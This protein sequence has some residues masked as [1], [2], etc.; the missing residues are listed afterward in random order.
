S[1]FL[2]SSMLFVKKLNDFQSTRGNS[3]EDIKEY[4]ER[5]YKFE[6][7]VLSNKGRD[8]TGKG[9]FFHDAR[10]KRTDCDLREFDIYFSMFRNI[11]GNGYENISIRSKVVFYRAPFGLTHLG[12]ALLFG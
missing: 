5:K 2:M 9:L 3:D 6:V 8:S 1:I 10:V 7:D 4:V 12:F 11:E